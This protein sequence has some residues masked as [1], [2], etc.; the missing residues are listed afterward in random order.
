MPQC[1]C[2]TRRR[3]RPPPPAA[4]HASTP[5]A[6]TPFLHCMPARGPPPLLCFYCMLGL[7]PEALA[8]SVTLPPPTPPY[9]FQA[10]RLPLP[11]FMPAKRLIPQSSDSDAPIVVTPR[12]NTSSLSALLAQDVLLSRA[13]SKQGPRPVHGGAAPAT[14][15]H[16]SNITSPS[17]APPKL[18]KFAAAAARRRASNPRIS[19]ASSAAPKTA[20][21]IPEISPSSFYPAKEPEWTKRRDC[22]AACSAPPL[23]LTRRRLARIVGAS[24]AGV[25]LGDGEFKES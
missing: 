12:K 5:T 3:R 14:P 10:T 11:Y 19:V 23:R 22:S 4:Q 7:R 15:S 13:G 2:H 8:P 21:P 16:P 18:A 25:E 6:R 17:A 9:L 20:G 1:H 24:A